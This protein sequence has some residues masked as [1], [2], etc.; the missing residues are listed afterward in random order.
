MIINRYKIQNVR[1][2]I[3]V[4]TAMSIIIL[5]GVFQSQIKQ[6]ENAL[7]N[8]SNHSTVTGYITNI[9]G[10]RLAGLEIDSKKADGILKSGYIEK[11]LTRA[12]LMGS[13]ISNNKSNKFD[14][15]LVGTN[16][17]DI[18]TN[19][20][21]KDIIFNN[22]QNTDFLQTNRAYCIVEQAFAQ[23]NN[24]KSG[25]KLPLSLYAPKYG[26]GA[27]YHMIDIGRG[28]LEIIGTYQR[29]AAKDGVNVIVPIQWLKDFV[30]KTE[31][32][33]YYDSISFNLKPPI[34]LNEFKQVLEQM[35]FSEV[36]DDAKESYIG[37]AVVINDQLF[38]EQATQ[39]QSTL[40]TYRT[41]CLPFYFLILL[42]I[43]SEAFLIMK[44]RRL[45][46]A[47]SMSLGEARQSIGMKMYAELMICYIF[48]VMIGLLFLY[49]TTD[50]VLQELMMIVLSFF[51]VASFGVLIALRFLF[52]FD[53]MQLLTQVD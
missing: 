35:Q 28:E 2:L 48:G 10:N 27:E 18:F 52:K 24:L 39:L 16:S 53:A 31:N 47:I 29:N 9:T 21:A 45:E 25:Q 22:N 26:N 42:L 51:I 34:Q 32:E 37:D 44:N 6:V 49:L 20:T 8:L 36:S 4:I 43:I 17:L 19:F 5:V 23:K 50:L 3:N 33:F 7:L 13:F 11:A 40:S 41:F 12:Q 30:E 38:I 15:L 1:T 14:A 46:V